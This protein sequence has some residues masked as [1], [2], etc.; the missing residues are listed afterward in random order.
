MANVEAKGKRPHRMNSHTVQEDEL[1]T[2]TR[3]E[4]TWGEVRLRCHDFKRDSRTYIKIRTLLDI[5]VRDE[6]DGACYGTLNQRSTP[7][8]LQ[9][10]SRGSLIHGKRC[11]KV[12]RFSNKTTDL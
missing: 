2:V 11:A 12:T 5:S 8:Y 4:A 7:I 1:S 3:N 9:G 6:A 10:I